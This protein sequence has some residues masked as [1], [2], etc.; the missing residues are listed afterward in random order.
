MRP[1]RNRY[2]P[3]QIGGVVSL[4]RVRDRTGEDEDRYSV[5]W[6]TRNGDLR[7]LS[8]TLPEETADA[9]ARLLAD[10]TGGVLRK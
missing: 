2:Q 10:F 7:W 8:P 9:A 6:H 5:S 1:S 4:T 3:Q